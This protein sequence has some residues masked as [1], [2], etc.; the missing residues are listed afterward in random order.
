MDNTYWVVMSG[1]PLDGVDRATALAALAALFQVPEARVE[2]MLAGKPVVVKKGMDQ[3]TA[4]RYLARLQQAGVAAKMVVDTPDLPQASGN[5]ADAAPGTEQA[6]GL[7]LAPLGSRL[8]DRPPPPD[9]QVDLS[10]LTLDPPGVVLVEPRQIPP[11]PID[12]SALTLAPRPDL[13]EESF[14]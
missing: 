2:G 10:G 6:S 3:A 8:S 5:R 12:T 13:A 11:P 4:Q 1:V 9:L 7:G 14:S